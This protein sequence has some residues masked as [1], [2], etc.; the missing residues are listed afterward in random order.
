MHRNRNWLCLV[1]MLPLLAACDHFP[2]YGGKPPGIVDPLLDQRGL[3]APADWNEV[4]RDAAYRVVQRASQIKDL[5]SR[6]LYVPMPAKP[7]RFTLAMHTFLIS[8]LTQMGLTVSQRADGSLPVEFE[9]QPVQL[10]RGL[11]LITTAS[12]GN[13]S[14]YL[15]RASDVYYVN[16]NDAQLYLDALNQP[17]PPPPPPTPVRKMPITGGA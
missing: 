8:G 17:P 14:R 3:R 15:F 1:L 6:T 9:V 2:Y 4:A 11:Q 10:E 12:I 13:G 5:S 7:T 16:S